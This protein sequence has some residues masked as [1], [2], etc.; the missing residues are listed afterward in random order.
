M[1]LI[2]VKVRCVEGVRDTGWFV[3]GRE[4]TLICGP[5]NSGKTALLQALQAL[6]P[7]YDIDWIKPFAEHP[8]TWRQDQYVRRVIPEKKTA[9]FMVFAAEARQVPQL[10]EIDADLIETD[11]IEVGRRLDNSRW[12]SF[13]EISASSRW[14]EIADDMQI[15][16]DSTTEEVIGQDKDFFSRLGGSDRI[17]GEVA[18]QC[19]TLLEKMEPHLGQ[20]QRKRYHHCLEK[21]QRRERFFKAEAQVAAWLPLTLYIAPGVELPPVLPLTR[22]ANEELWFRLPV[23]AALLTRLQSQH[24]LLEPGKNIEILHARYEEPITPLLA[25]FREHGWPIPAFSI[26]GDAICFA[27]IP[28]T[29]LHQRLYLIGA[30]CL[31]ARLCHE[32]RPLLLLDGFDRDLAGAEQAEMIRFLQTLGRWCQL[33]MTT[34]DETVAAADGWQSV[35]SIGP[36]GLLESG[37]NSV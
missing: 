36:G 32:T 23:V 9:V 1:N 35:L 6:N 2:Q 33:L 28:K 8:R 17:Q 19:L 16:L 3:P 31:L 30:V 21:V 12:V 15:L 25:L 11:R 24:K 22:A 5:D 20:S 27:D 14:R 4:T 13:V 10:A 18:N 37:L 7:A 34:A 26:V 29:V